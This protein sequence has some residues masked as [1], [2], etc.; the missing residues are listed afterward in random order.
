MRVVRGVG[1]I[2]IVLGL[3]LLFFVVYEEVGTSIITNH[4]QSVL[5]EAFDPTIEKPP[6]PSESASSAE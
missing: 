2:F 3:T 5:A 6:I 1:N 4:R